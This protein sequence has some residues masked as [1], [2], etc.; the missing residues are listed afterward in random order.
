MIACVSFRWGFDRVD[1]FGGR[2]GGDRWFVGVWRQW[3]GF[4]F[5]SWVAVFFFF[6]LVGVDGILCV[7]GAG[8]GLKCV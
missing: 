8:G 2:G 5:L 1:F 4:G 7:A 6:F 3:R